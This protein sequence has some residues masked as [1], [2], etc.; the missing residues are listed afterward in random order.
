LLVPDDAVVGV[1]D[2]TVEL[3]ELGFVLE[4]VVL[5]PPW[6]VCVSAGGTDE[7][8]VPPFDV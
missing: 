2:P 1:V 3:G 6:V 7:V 8:V 5:L 4:V